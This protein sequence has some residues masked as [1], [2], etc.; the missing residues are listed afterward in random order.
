MGQCSDS[1]WALLNVSSDGGDGGKKGRVP[2]A[3]VKFSFTQ[4]WAACVLGRGNSVNGR[5]RE[6]LYHTIRV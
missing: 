3:T 6:S 5:S 1:A 4:P 2:P